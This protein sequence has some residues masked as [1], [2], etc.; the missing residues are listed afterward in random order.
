[1]VK[2]Q[3]SQ[4]AELIRNACHPKK[5]I[6]FGSQ[7]RGTATQTSDF[8]IMVILDQITDRRQEIVKLSRLIKPLGIRAD[9]VV[10]SEKTF[11]EWCDTPGSLYYEAA[12]EGR[13][14]LDEAA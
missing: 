9:I 6:L 12:Q 1:M 8:D 2:T 3:V 5:I 4:I 11:S 14:I 7:A 10:V 13:I